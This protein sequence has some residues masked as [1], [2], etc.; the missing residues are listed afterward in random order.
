[1]H[2]VHREL[3]N[4]TS[5]LEDSGYADFLVCLSCGVYSYLGHCGH[6][7]KTENGENGEQM[8]SLIRYFFMVIASFCL[9]AAVVMILMD[10]IT[11][12]LAMF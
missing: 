5:R 10:T 6:E 7:L 11:R 1:V 2:S 9:G 3:D 12:A 4:A 8:A